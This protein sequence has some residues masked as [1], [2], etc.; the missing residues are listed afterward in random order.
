MLENPSFIPRVTPDSGPS[1]YPD[2]GISNRVYLDP[3]ISSGVRIGRLL[4]SDS[5][6]TSSKVSGLDY[7]YPSISL[8]SLL[9]PLAQGR[10]PIC[11]RGNRRVC[12]RSINKQ[13]KKHPHIKIRIFMT[14]F[15]MTCFFMKEKG[16]ITCRKI[17]NEVRISV[18]I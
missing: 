1:D 8:L 13:R 17:K 14:T 16:I 5:C 18:Y 12:K 15:F 10:W 2:P 9:V 4:L 11:N 3:F 6:V 7:R